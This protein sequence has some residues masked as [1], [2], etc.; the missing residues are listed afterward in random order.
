MALNFPN[1]PTV[2]Q[3]YTD[4]T[5]GFS[6]EWTG[7]LW[8]SYSAATSSQIREIDDISGSFNGI[9]TSFALLS[10]GASVLPL[11]PQQLIVSVG[12]V[13]QNPGEDYTIS[14]SNIVFSTAPTS[15]L[16][17]FATSL[18]PAQNIGV[19]NDGSV[20]PVKLSTGGPTWNSSGDLLI[21]GISTFSGNVSV[22]GN[23]TFAGNVSIAGTITYEDV[24]N[25]DSIGIV[26]ARA[27]LNVGAGGT[28]IA[29]SSNN[30]GIGSTIPQAKLDVVGGI[31]GSLVLETAVSAATTSVSF[32]NIPSWVKR[33]T[34]MFFDVSTNGTDY[35]IVQLGTSGGIADDANYFSMTGANT[36]SNTASAVNYTTG[37]G[38]QSGAAVNSVQ[39]QY[40]FVNVTGDTW[41]ASGIFANN[42]SALNYAVG[43]RTLSGVL[44]QLRIT[45]TGGTDTFDAGTINIMYEG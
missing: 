11:N 44:T 33:V 43:R 1:S 8:K 45:S 32:T 4:S 3:I 37:F 17:F 16:T 14:G 30:V 34:V 15:G 24:T 36:T 22:S 28:I 19:P 10:G 20:T 18:G 9:T 38:I 21:S 25:V 42:T 41:I 31:N 5:S 13:I 26:T 27:G 2:G 40:T 35:L 7:V 39:G 23:A 12:G 29:T 6:Y